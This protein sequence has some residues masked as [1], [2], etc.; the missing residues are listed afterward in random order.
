MSSGV[1]HDVSPETTP[2]DDPKPYSYCGSAKAQ[3]KP[4]FNSYRN[5]LLGD[6]V[7]WGPC[8][9]HCLPLWLGRTI[10]TVELSIGSNY[11]TF[12]VE[13]WTL[14]YSKKEPKSLVAR[15]C[16]TRRWTP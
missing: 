7:L 10:S 13:W 9:G 16:W 5:V 12:V 11:V 2:Q 3:P 6:F 4:C 14:I 15:E 1:G 8:D